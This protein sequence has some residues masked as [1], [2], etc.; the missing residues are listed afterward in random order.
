VSAPLALAAVLA[1]AVPLALQRAYRLPE[2]FVEKW[3]ADRGVELTPETRPPITGYLRSVRV[4]RTWGGVVGA[5]VPSL[6]EWALTGRVQVLGFGTDGESAPLGFGTI[7]VGY[8]VGV[9][10]A[11][12]RHPRAAGSR[13]VASLARRELRDYLPARTVHEQRALAATSALGTL[14]I[15]VL[16]YPPATSNPGP[17]GLAAAAVLVVGFAIGAE[18]IE[19]WLV[20]RPQPFESAAAVAADDAVRA[21][22][23]QAFAGAA[24][25]LL[26]LY[27][28]G[29]ALV[30]QASTV[31]VLQALMIV[32][33]VILLIA[34]LAACRGI[35]E[36]SWIV[37]RAHGHAGEASA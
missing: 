33:A 1:V 37:R 28:C 25:A 18:A 8:L 14:A 21:Q 29:I 26:S 3:A 10:V 13:R 22:S 32:P 24:L 35:G 36:G 15:G 5:I 9:L 16:P 17:L 7:F 11:E 31:P 23:I 19:R 12:I 4:M 20:R 27:C 34:S 30:W 2:V 6:A